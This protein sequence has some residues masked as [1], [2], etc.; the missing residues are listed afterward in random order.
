MAAELITS[1]CNFGKME[2]ESVQ[3][4]VEIATQSTDHSHCCVPECNSDARYNPE[5]KVSCQK[6]EKKARV[7]QQNKQRPWKV[8]QGMCLN[9]SILHFSN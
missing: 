3:E 8:I 1:T 5:N 4:T 9:P 2:E 7:D 6:S